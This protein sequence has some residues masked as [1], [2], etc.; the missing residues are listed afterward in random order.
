MMRTQ[1]PQII[2]TNNVAPNMKQTIF[3]RLPTAQ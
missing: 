3:E 1:T 2:Y